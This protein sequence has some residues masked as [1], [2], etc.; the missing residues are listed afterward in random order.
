MADDKTKVNGADRRLINL[1]ED[2]EVRDWASVLN[3]DEYE[4]RRA[5]QAVGNSAE[6]VRSYLAQNRE[7]AH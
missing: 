1:S 7:R 5:V 4:L 2:Y 3:C 6:A